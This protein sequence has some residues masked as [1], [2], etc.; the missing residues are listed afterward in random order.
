[1]GATIR[2]K[3][4]VVQQLEC[5]E[6]Y[7]L[8]FFYIVKSH[9][10]YNETMSLITPIHNDRFVHQDLFERPPP[11]VWHIILNFLLSWGCTRAI[12][13]FAGSCQ[14][15][16][17]IV[18]DFITRYQSSKISAFIHG[19][20]FNQTQSPE[21][22]GPYDMRFGGQ[23][24]EGRFYILQDTKLVKSSYE[25]HSMKESSNFNANQY[26]FVNKWNRTTQQLERVFPK[27]YAT[28]AL[29][30]GQ[31]AALYTIP[32]EEGIC[33]LTHSG[34]LIDNRYGPHWIQ[35]PSDLSSNK[36]VYAR[37][38]NLLIL[39][40]LKRRE[41]EV[42]FFEL[43]LHTD[44]PQLIQSNRFYDIFHT[45]VPNFEKTRKADYYY[46]NAS[47]SIYYFG[48]TIFLAI[49]NSI[50]EIALIEGALQ[51]VKGYTL[52]SNSYYPPLLK[53]NQN[54]LVCICENDCRVINVFDRTD[55]TE[56][57]AFTWETSGTPTYL[58]LQNDFLFLGTNG[59][60]EVI[61]LPRKLITT[62]S[63]EKDCVAIHAW[64]DFVVSSGALSLHV[65]VK[66]QHRPIDLEKKDTC[67]VQTFEW[68]NDQQKKLSP[69]IKNFLDIEYDSEFYK[70]TTKETSEFIEYQEHSFAEPKQSTICEKVSLAVSIFFLLATIAAVTALY[71]THTGT[72]LTT[73]LPILLGG[74]ILSLLALAIASI[75]WHRKWTI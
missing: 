8:F 42:L 27:D 22:E 39:S 57:V 58:H 10:L 19:T 55:L 6:K 17:E 45:L 52:H 64:L 47:F 66:K 48:N 53:A 29:Q 5:M 49:R 12:I 13:Q 26:G 50:H 7:L 24:G 14:E 21:M 56:N 59:Q 37:V 75:R 31:E 72:F 51:H 38:D 65:L 61:H 54:W 62:F 11:E 25:Q 46:G 28:P 1:M 4:D 15:A 2:K 23:D 32:F 36:G 74:G 70:Y 43:D 34:I 40:Y 68:K 33:Y 67:Y 9:P 60:I 44:A 16:Q 18:A 20:H 3:R 30:S 69:L 35:L 63:L 71:F 73:R 41:I